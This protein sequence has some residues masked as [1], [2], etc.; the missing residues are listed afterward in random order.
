MG[1]KGAKTTAEP[2]KA[3]TPTNTKAARSKVALRT[4]R[5]NCLGKLHQ[6]RPQT[7][8]TSEHPPHEGRGANG[9]QHPTPHQSPRRRPYQPTPTPRWRERKGAKTTSEPKKAATPTNTK[10]ARSKVA[11][12]TPTVNCLGKKNGGAV[13]NP[14][15]SLFVQLQNW[16]WQLSSPSNE[17]LRE[18]WKEQPERYQPPS[19]KQRGTSHP[20]ATEAAP[21]SESSPGSSVKL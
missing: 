18:V 21:S 2:K 13:F 12:R 16:P 6:R 1:A 9:N 15:I 3:A 7:V 17:S 4:L 19:L 20:S 5:I 8:Y 14:N 11:L 10:A